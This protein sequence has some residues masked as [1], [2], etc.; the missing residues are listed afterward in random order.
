MLPQQLK[1]L[2]QFPPGRMRLQGRPS[3]QQ[4]SPLQTPAPTARESRE[5]RGTG[6][7]SSDATAVTAKTAASMKKAEKCMIDETAFAV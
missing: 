4:L 2:Q 1:P 5:L 6:L 7:T 3:A